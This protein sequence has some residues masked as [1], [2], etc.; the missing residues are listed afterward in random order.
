MNASG[1]NMLTSL[2]PDTLDVII[3]QLICQKVV[4][5]FASIFLHELACAFIFSG[6]Y[7]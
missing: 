2:E 1:K 4:F 6:S 7:L 5:S 3:N